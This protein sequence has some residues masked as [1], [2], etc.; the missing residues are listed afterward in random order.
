MR[1]RGGG[2]ERWG[3]GE[4]RGW[5]VGRVGIER[6]ERGLGWGWHTVI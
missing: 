5:G 4:G 1:E 2:V 6:Q 3:R